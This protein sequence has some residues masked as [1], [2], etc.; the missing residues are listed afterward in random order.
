MGKFLGS[1][2]RGSVIL[3]AKSQK[4]PQ[5]VTENRKRHKSHRK[6]A[7]KP[8]KH[9]ARN[10]QMPCLSYESFRVIRPNLLEVRARTDPDLPGLV[11]FAIPVEISKL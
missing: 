7:G 2:T 3:L 8:E 10:R 6:S 9:L 5:K 11:V 4:G 1:L